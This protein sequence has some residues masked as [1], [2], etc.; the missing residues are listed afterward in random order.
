MSKRGIRRPEIRTFAKRVFR[1][2]ELQQ[3]DPR[4]LLA[5][6]ASLAVTEISP[7]WFEEL[8]DSSTSGA[9]GSRSS[10]DVV[11][12]EWGDRKVEVFAEEWIVQLDWS[13][14][15][16]LNSV[17]GASA[18]LGSYVHGYEILGGLGRGGQ[19]LL[20]TS[21]SSMTDVASWLDTN[22][23]VDYYEPNGAL[24]LSQITND[25]SYDQ[26]WGLPEMDVPEAWD[27]TMGSSTHVVAVIDTG[28][29]YSHPDLTANMWTNP[30]EIPGNG[31]DDDGNGFVDD[32]HGF[33]FAND[34]GD[35]M[36]DNDHGTHVAGTIAATGNNGVGVVGVAPNTQIMALKFM[37]ADGFGS[38]SDAVRALNYA[39]LM[40]DSYGV[41]VIVTNNSWGGGG[42]SQ[43]LHDAIATS[44]QQDIL[45]VAAAGNETN[46]N[47]VSPSYPANYDLDNVISVAAT[48]S[49]DALASFSNSG[50]Q[51]VHVAAPGVGIL[52]TLAGGG[53]GSMSGTSM[54]APHV[55]GVAALAAAIMPDAT[56]AE[57]RQAITQ[58]VDSVP[59]LTNSVS[60]GGRVNA[61][62]SLQ[63][64]GISVVSASV[65]DGE[66]LSSP[67][68]D[69]TI[70]FSHPVDGDSIVPAAVKINGQSATGFSLVDGDSVQF[71]FSSS[72]V[73]AEGQQTLTVDHGAVRRLSDQSFSSSWTAT[74]FY[75]T[76]PTSVASTSVDG[77]TFSLPPS[78]ID[79]SF[80]DPIS[81]ATLDRTD[82]GLS[83][84]TVD[85]VTA[86]D[87]STV[88]LDVDFDT[89][90]ADIELTVAEGSI[91][92]TDGVPVTGYTS[93]F[94]IAGTTITRHMSPDKNVPLV[95]AGRLFSTL[96]VN[97]SL[98]IEDIDVEVNI[99]HTW[100]G[101]LDVYLFA[102]DGTWVELFTDVGGSGDGFHN[103]IL[104]SD[105]GQLIRSGTAP[106]EGRYRPEGDLSILN[107]KSAEGV[108]KL[109]IVD[110][111]WS[112]SGTL[113]DWGLRINSNVAPSLDSIDD[114]ATHISDSTH[115]VAL[116]ATDL[117][118]DSIS[119]SADAREV[120]GDAAEQLDATHGFWASSRIE[121][122]N[123]HYNA[124]GFGEKYFK[125]ATDHWFFILPTG[126]VHR[127][128]DSIEASPQVGQLEARHHAAPQLLLHPTSG[129][130]A[131]VELTI[132]SA[133]QLTVATQ[134]ALP[135]TYRISVHAR[136]G[137]LTTTEE[138]DVSLVNSAPTLQA[139][140][141]Q[142]ILPNDV[143]ITVNLTASD[144]DG[145]QLSYTAEAFDTSAQLARELDSQYG[146]KPHKKSLATDYHF[147][148][149][150]QQER[151]IQSDVGWFFILPDGSLYQWSQSIEQSI[152]VGT[153][154]STYHED[155][156]RLHNP[157]ETAPV[158]VQL[159]VDQATGVLTITPG[160]NAPNDFGVRVDVMDGWERQQQEF[161]VTMFN[162]APTLATIANQ[163]VTSGDPLTITLDAADADGQALTITGDV[164][165][166][167]VGR[168]R[169]LDRQLGLWA[170]SKTIDKNY[171]HDLR[172]HGEKYIKD[173]NK[174]WHFILPNGELYRFAS[175]VEDSVLIETLDSRYHDNPSLLTS[176]KNA[177]ALDVQIAINN[178]SLTAT[179]PPGY[180][181]TFQIVVSATD[182]RAT[183]SQT[184]DVVVQ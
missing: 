179:T 48:D 86:L 131:D 63:Q 112:D 170:D 42:F 19:L 117:D 137:S 15:S 184:F 57:I 114:I 158:D 61:H 124:R 94:A 162:T 50:V 104:D 47:D 169:Q 32:V 91:T 10:D 53:Y 152:L 100:N 138:F 49:N 64:L 58:G 183:A 52:S 113:L 141:D 151:Y 66:L 118:N 51:T 102:P 133:N 125:D 178:P 33:D 79:I 155:P 144:Q 89:L 9:L 23:F 134:A 132:D 65:S 142:Q 175:S 62:Q 93:S 45:F 28:V 146:L 5:G 3:L 40:K 126:S 181:G 56:A 83:W 148:T 172:G 2:S 76:T 115:Q 73:V 166:P 85:G 182:G 153:L 29:D 71:Q 164:I 70:D 16:N 30:G 68:N 59:Q 180:Q 20:R 1:T 81:T 121:S 157:S 119:Y 72:P 174:K 26:Q 167:H 22:Q 8:R 130:P 109:R 107:G 145:D 136:D 80:T 74:F 31:I 108:W 44:G 111:Y 6:D 21:G 103:T 37:N 176:G 36:D 69:V 38:T 60:T 140:P 135:T 168:A 154:N 161:A 25:P 98:W 120:G 41:D 95:D 11:E 14:A 160:V 35:P 99:D 116:S 92:G 54:A 173:A 90:D 128:V 4:L 143:D 82:F 43:S 156:A 13:A 129:L 122:R 96:R 24:P 177:P 87:D 84:G 149:R 105:A 12:M 106:F 27:T 18:L 139:V 147:N 163:Q 165:D 171:H 46:N 55:A 39:T 123:Y 67:V 101:D 127:W 88:R 110:D 78:Q 7:F 150:G 75:D 17:A 97:E 34:D 159:S 77:Q